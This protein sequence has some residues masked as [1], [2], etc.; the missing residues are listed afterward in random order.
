MKA[1]ALNV[2]TLTPS[3][4]LI[5]SNQKYW[6]SM[7]ILP[8]TEKFV[9]PKLSNKQYLSINFLEAP[10]LGFILAFMVRFYNTDISNKTGY[11]FRENE[12]LVAYLFMSVV[13]AL[14]IGMMVSAEEIIKDRKILKREKF[15]NLSR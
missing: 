13:V 2:E 8:A 9:L 7:A 3:K 14:F 5:S 1:N 6:M 10:L 15:L 12:N 4:F 11:I